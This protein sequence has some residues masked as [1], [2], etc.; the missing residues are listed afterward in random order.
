MVK[1]TSRDCYP[2]WETQNVDMWINHDQNLYEFT[3]RLLAKL[4]LYRASKELSTHLQGNTTPDGARFT[5]QAI[6]YT[7]SNMEV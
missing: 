7:L 6:L 2:N 5:Y 3:Y 4:G 1:L